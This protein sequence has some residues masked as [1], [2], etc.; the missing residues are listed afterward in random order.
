M[1]L[2]IVSF[3]SKRKIVWLVCSLYVLICSVKY[4]KKLEKNNCY[5]FLPKKWWWKH[6]LLGLNPSQTWRWTLG[7]L[8]TSE[9][10]IF[11]L[12]DTPIA[13]HTSLKQWI[14]HVQKCPNFVESICHQIWL[15]LKDL[16]T[17]AWHL[18]IF[19]EMQSFR[20]ESLCAHSPRAHAESECKK[21]LRGPGGS[22]KSWIH[23]FLAFYWRSF[24]PPFRT[25]S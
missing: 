8:V 17:L 16:E 12:I 5:Q 20:K 1:A 22:K 4:W 6:S 13:I 7:S 11:K 3:R 2:Q 21:S 24:V 19:W 14:F 10:S 25:P 15:P 9:A 18:N 23:F